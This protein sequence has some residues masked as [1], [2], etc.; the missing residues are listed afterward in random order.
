M[1]PKHLR[2]VNKKKNT[3]DQPEK[4]THKYLTR[5]YEIIKSYNYDNILSK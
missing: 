2:V 1:N 4:L 3:C 5:D